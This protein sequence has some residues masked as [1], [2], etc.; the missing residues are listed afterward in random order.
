MTAILYPVAASADAA[1]HAPT[2]FAERER[3]A[4][5]V[6][7]GAVSFATEAVGPAFP[8]REAALDA[9]AGRVDDERPGRVAQAMDQRWCQLR[10]VSADEGV[11]PKRSGKPGPGATIVRPDFRDGR[12]WPVREPASVTSTLWRLSV[13]YW[14]ILEAPAVADTPAR[15]LRRDLAG[16]DIDAPALN[17]LA[18]QPLRAAK[19][20]QPLDIGLFEV[21][22]PE[23]PDLIMPDE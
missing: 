6:A 8:N 22:M 10:P 15:A 12:R 16:R 2:G 23:S 21:R 13:S 20:Q 1:L 17:A 11:K 3:E 14:R 5:R 18:R 19:P 4:G 7:A 9:Y